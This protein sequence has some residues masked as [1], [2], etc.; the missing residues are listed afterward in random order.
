MKKDRKANW[1]G[2]FAMIEDPHRR[3]GEFSKKGREKNESA[4]QA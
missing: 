3:E 2:Q 1:K 4:K